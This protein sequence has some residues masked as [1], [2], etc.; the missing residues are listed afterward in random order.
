MCSKP[1]PTTRLI[2]SRPFW[3]RTTPL[4]GRFNGEGNASLLPARLQP[5]L[6]SDWLRD[7]T[8]TT[9]LRGRMIKILLLDYDVA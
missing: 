6:S 4:I 8:D 1:S 3:E 2:R 9:S 7:H 5:A